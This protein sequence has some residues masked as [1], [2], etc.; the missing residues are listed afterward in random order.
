MGS[1]AASPANG[2]LDGELVETFITCLEREGL[3]FAHDADFELS[4]TSSGGSA[5][6]AQPSLN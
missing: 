2:Q 3:T 5:S 1:C 6:M 4:S